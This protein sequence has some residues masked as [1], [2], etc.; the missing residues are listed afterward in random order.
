MGDGANHETF[1]TREFV[2][3]K[4]KRKS[5]GF[6]SEEVDE[7][8][9]I[10]YGLDGRK[11]NLWSSTPAE[12]SV[13]TSPPP[14][15][16]K[17]KIMSAGRPTQF[18]AVPVEERAEDSH[19]Q[20]LPWGLEWHDDHPNARHQKRHVEE[21][22]PFGKSL[23][24]RGSSRGTRTAT[25]S[26]KENPTLDGFE[27]ALKFDILSKA[28][29]EAQGSANIPT[30]PQHEGSTSLHLMSSMKEPTEVMLYGFSPPTQWAA[31]LYYENASRGKI[32]EDYPRDPPVDYR[33]IPNSFNAAASV[34]TQSLTRKE[35]ALA[36]HYAGGNCWIKVTFDSAEAADRAIH[37]SPHCIKGYWVY[38]SR[39]KG[40]KPTVDEPIT[41]R[42]EAR[43][44]G[45]LGAKKR[46]QQGSQTLGPSFTQN[47]N[48]RFRPTPI[49]PQSQQKSP[50]QPQ[51]QPQSQPQ[52]Q[53]QTLTT[54]QSSSTATSA[55][56]TAP[57]YP[58][59][60]GNLSAPSPPSQ[61]Q[62]P[63]S[64]SASSSDLVPQ[65]TPRTFTHFPT[66][67]RT[68]IHP[69]HEAF[70]PHPSWMDATLR[71]LAAAGWI[72]G[73]VIGEGIPVLDNGEMDWAH[74]SFYWKVFH[75]IDIVFGT[76]FCGLKYE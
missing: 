46:P 9:Q 70:L 34:R 35:A 68:A 45:S 48:M 63:S 67:Q 37:F 16:K 10:T 33:R 27:S 65:P 12:K 61:Q 52:P 39:Y 55:T 29:V 13:S 64:S 74:A 44:Q 17:R 4:R 58:D 20:T 40:V 1:L 24:R 18:H 69:A 75:W 7:V 62:Q 73:D 51:P 43:D 56:A 57:I 54:P 53:P 11:E 76:D 72:P 5:D 50:E 21:K 15:P 32:C 25:P 47:K 60:S 23:R 36:R 49:F 41:E 22:G 19:G 6:I 59:L 66:V 31:I 30:R 2:T 28:A 38:A 3:R 8:F 42:E 26:K 71:R 14:A